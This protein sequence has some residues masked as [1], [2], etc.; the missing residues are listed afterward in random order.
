MKPRLARALAVGAVGVGVGLVAAGAV[1]TGANGG[2]AIE[3]FLFGLGF[4]GFAFVG[5]VIV[6]RRPDNPMGW[7]FLA[8]GVL[9]AAGS[10]SDQYALYA[11]VTD[12][13]SLPLPVV[14]AWYGEWYWI[15]N[16]FGLL[17]FGPLLFP[18]GRPLSQRWRIV[19]G[20][21]AFACTAAVVYAALDPRLDL[22][23]ADVSVSNPIGVGAF[24]EL[25]SGVT[26]G[27]VVA[28]VLLG[29]LASVVCVVLRFRR[30]R[31][32]ERQQMKWFTYAAVMTVVGFV[33]LGVLDAVAGIR[34]D[35]GYF[36]ITLLMPVA[37]AVAILRYRLYDIDVVINRT[38][39]YVALT[40][41]LGLVYVG[42][43]FVFQRVLSPLTAESDLAIA[44]STLAVAALFRPLRARVQRFIDRRFY[45]S[46]YDAQRT[47]DGFSERLRDE[48]DLDALGAH[49]Q[50]VVALTVRPAHASLWLREESR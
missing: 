48:V 8:M 5:A 13:K 35:I 22:A 50:D 40:A 3:A 14:A 12:P 4:A 41:I 28:T 25:E 46:K 20:A 36:G 11:Y 29:A 37:A 19:L 33:L 24:D 7:L 49:L 21:L 23:G 47:L 32:Q 17:C 39:V 27:L 10:F 1:L 2:D 15:T 38:L 31:G 18:T 30:S 26:G 6:V 45:R 43:I 16:L 44:G 34:F 42:S 9:W